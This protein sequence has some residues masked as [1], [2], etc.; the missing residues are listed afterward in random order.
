MAVDVGRSARQVAFTL[1]VKSAKIVENIFLNNGVLVLLGSKGRVRVVRG[2]NRFDERTHLGMNSNVAHRDPFAQIDSNFQDNWRTAQYG[3]ATIDGTT[4]VNFVEMAQNQGDHAIGTQK[5]AQ[6]SFDDL[7]NTFPNKVSDALM[8]ATSGAADPLSLIEELPATA[9]GSQTRTTGGL[10]RSDYPGPD[11]TKAWQTQHSSSGADLAT[12]AGIATVTAFLRK[13]SEGS[14]KNMQP[15]ICLTTD[16]AFA[17]ASGGG[18]ILRRYSVSEKMM[19]LG[20][21]NLMINEAILISDRN[22]PA[23]GLLALNTNFMRVQVLAGPNTKQTGDVQV[24]GDGAVSV[25]L[26]ISKPVESEDYLKY[27][28]KAW[29][30]YNLTFGALK[31]HGRMDNITEATL[32]AD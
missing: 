19:K 10:V 7:M 2:G 25:P 4:P 20:F 14:A 24:V 29:L 18:D 13:C 22:V 21:N 28:I 30:T 5:L 31:Y 12:A 23:K 6:E 16:G 11:R 3:Q 17:Q 15:D 9:F 8:A 32:A 27:T 1:E 26:Q